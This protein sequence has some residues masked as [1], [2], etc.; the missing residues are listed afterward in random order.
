MNFFSKEIFSFKEK[1]F[2]MDLS[3]LSVKVIQLHNDGFRDKIVAFS[4]QDIPNGCIEDGKIINKEKAIRAIKSAILRAGPKKINTKKVICSL[5]ESKVFLRILSIPHM[6]EEEIGEA[7]KWEIEASIPLSIDQV[8][9]DWQLIGSNKS[10]QSVLTVAVA[11]DVVDELVEILEAAGLEVYGLEAESVAMAR[12]LV[13]QQKKQKKELSRGD[14]EKDADA[15]KDVALIV[16]LGA[17]RTG[18]ILTEGNIPFFTSSVPFSSFG[19]TSMISRILGISNEDAEKIKVTQGMS[20]CSIN[21]NLNES[22]GAYLESLATEIEKSIDFYQSIDKMD[23]SS[24]VEDII[25]CGGGANLKGIIP[26][27]V[28][29]LGRKIQVCDPWVNFD[30]GNNLP[31]INKEKASQFVTAIGLAMRK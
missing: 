29:R 30:F 3:D 8:Y 5:S 24:K 6:A 4:D 22:M 7:I 31:I 25:I 12:S 20:A 1:Y 23:H 15:H 21:D 28:K 2:G 14:K 27:L 10:S 13:L 11:R 9:Y 18:F 19:I 17:Q 26:Y 16:D